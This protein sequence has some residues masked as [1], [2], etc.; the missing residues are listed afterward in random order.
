MV[1]DVSKSKREIVRVTGVD[2][3]IDVSVDVR[4]QIFQDVSNTY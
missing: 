2:V 1:F 3:N 4:R